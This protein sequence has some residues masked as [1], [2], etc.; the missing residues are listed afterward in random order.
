MGDLA[1][2]IAGEAANALRE[3]ATIIGCPA[4]ADPLTDLDGLVLAVRGMAER[5]ETVRVVTADRDAAEAA[6]LPLAHRFGQRT[7]EGLA[8]AIVAAFASLPEATAV[9]HAAAVRAAYLAGFTCGYLSRELALE[10]WRRSAIRA[11]LLA[12]VGADVLA[13]VER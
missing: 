12:R 4:N 3:I 1:D 2:V 10:R 5:A 11:N 6:Y 7:H 13:E 9:E 8:A